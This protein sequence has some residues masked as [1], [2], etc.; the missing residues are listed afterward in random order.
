MYTPS[1]AWVHATEV[2][3]RTLWHLSPCLFTPT[4]THNFDPVVLSCS[5]LTCMGLFPIDLGKAVCH[6]P[7]FMMSKMTLLVPS[8]IKYKLGAISQWG[9]LA[10]SPRW[11]VDSLFPWEKAKRPGP[12]RTQ[13]CS[14]W[15][16]DLT[17]PCLCLPLRSSWAWWMGPRAE[18]RDLKGYVLLR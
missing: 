2:V 11:P 5:K 4:L 15:V 9:N 12:H 8:Y 6:R 18:A 14:V 16:L 10:G 1:C 7:V 13:A 17:L 3:L